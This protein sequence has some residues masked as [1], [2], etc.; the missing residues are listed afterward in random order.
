MDYSDGDPD[1]EAR[2]DLLTRTR[3]A[4]ALTENGFQDSRESLAFLES[5]AGKKAVIGL[6]VEGILN[7]LHN[8]DD[9][10]S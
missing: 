5:P 10:I 9:G 6:H 1:K 7:N 2:F 3:C 8:R 4:A